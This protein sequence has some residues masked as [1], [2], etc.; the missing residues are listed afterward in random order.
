MSLADQILPTW[1]HP[2]EC[3][4]GL[5]RRSIALPNG[6]LKLCLCLLCSLAVVSLGCA[7]WMPDRT[8]EA[9]ASLPSPPLSPDSVTVE[10][11]LVRFPFDATEALQGI[12]QSVDETVIDLELRRELDKNGLRAGL[13][14]GELP[15]AVVEQLK[16][17]GLEQTTDALEHAGLAA[18]VDNKRRVMSC[19]AGRRREFIVR[20]ELTEPMTVVTSIN[21]SLTGETFER[22][23]ALFDLRVTPHSDGQATVQLVPEI[24]HGNL[25]Q[26][27]VS[28]E[29]GVRPEVK[30]RQATWKPLTIQARLQPQQFLVVS[31]TYPPK[32][33]GNALFVT[34][35]AEQTEQHVVLL[36]RLAQT[37]MDELFAAELVEQAHALTER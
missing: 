17:T 4:G 21:G 20:R 31:G 33:L 36:I 11:V 3:D 10:T 32:S 35:T 30:R 26:T 6:A 5:P 34:K 13:L 2:R 28:S 9:K 18:D 24:Q 12:W 37:Q 19:R 7:K 14:R 25:Q 23:T 29:L 22:A 8:V 1:L 27:F 16:K 15:S